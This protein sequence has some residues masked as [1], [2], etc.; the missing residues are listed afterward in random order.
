MAGVGDPAPG[1]HQVL[2]G[3]DVPNRAHRND[4]AFAFAADARDREPT[5]LRLEREAKQL[6]F[7]AV[8][9]FLH[10]PTVNFVAFQVVV[11]QCA[12]DDALLDFFFE[13]FDAVKFFAVHQVSYVW[14]GI[15][16][17]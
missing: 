13:P 17:D 5:V 15:Y 1:E 6:P 14:V 8:G 4:L 2:S 11:A 9:G 3:C 12:D 7:E 10:L 16:E